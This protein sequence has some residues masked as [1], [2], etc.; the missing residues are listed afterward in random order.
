MFAIAGGGA[1][2]NGSRQVSM[3]GMEAP[4]PAPW[5]AEDMAKKSSEWIYPLSQ[6]QIGE[7]MDRVTK[8]EQD[9]VDIK[10]IT[11]E[12]FPL[13]N[14]GPAL[15]DMYHELTEGRGFVLIRGLPVQEMTTC[16]T[17]KMGCEG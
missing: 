14:V 3:P 9:G 5:Y 6:R 12:N 8:L 2:A 17:C 10:D 16:S 7:L 15:E 4:D 1:I 13:P 11:R